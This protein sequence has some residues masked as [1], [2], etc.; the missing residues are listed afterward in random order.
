MLIASS[1]DLKANV[2]TL[3]AVNIAMRLMT[4]FTQV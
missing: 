1:G 2:M 3:S 4:R